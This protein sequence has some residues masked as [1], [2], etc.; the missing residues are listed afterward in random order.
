MSPRDVKELEAFLQE[1]QSRARIV[2][3]DRDTT[4]VASAAE[5]LGVSPDR[6]VK[7][8]VF[9]AGEE[10]VLVI[11]AGPDRVDRR[12]LAEIF[13]LPSGKVRLATPEEVL[14]ATGYPVGGVPPVG[15]ARPIKV[16]IDR[17]V[18]QAPTTVFGGGGADRV[19]LEIEPAELIRLTGA[20]IIDLT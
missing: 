16:Y 17:R 12:R 11:A 1:R 5:A 3:L 20:Q 2:R 18:A 7:S 4:T 13:G 6:I 10:P 15:H 9:I 19:L 14:A 8:L